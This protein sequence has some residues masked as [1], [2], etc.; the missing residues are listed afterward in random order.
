MSYNSKKAI[1][2]TAGNIIIL[3]AY[4]IYVLGKTVAGSEDLRPWAISIL[5]FTGAGIALLIIIEIL[6]HIFSA[7]GIAVKERSQ[8]EKSI[9]QTI[10]S[11]MIEDERDKLISLKSSFTAFVCASAGFIA[12]MIFLVFANN[13]A[14]S[15]HIMFSGFCGGSIIQGVVSI[16]YYEKGVRIG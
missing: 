8:D 12:A 3:S 9:K 7:I 15:L 13:N 5:A 11:S 6:F 1:A 14:A 10:S 4:I 16:Y 2:R